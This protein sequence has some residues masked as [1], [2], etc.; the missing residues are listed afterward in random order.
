MI[1]NTTGA[2]SMSRL[3]D[4]C[5]IRALHRF[6]FHL[7]THRTCSQTRG[8]LSA[9]HDLLHGHCRKTPHAIKDNSVTWVVAE[10]EFRKFLRLWKSK[11]S[12]YRYMTLILS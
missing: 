1:L 3:R 12:H 2:G 7:Y 6:S 11:F 10:V 5:S 8:S 4:T 9:T